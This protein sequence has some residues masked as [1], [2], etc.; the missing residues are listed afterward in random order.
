MV[1]TCGREGSSFSRVHRQHARLVN[2]RR[3]QNV[4]SQN[5]MH[6]GELFQRTPRQAAA[7][8]I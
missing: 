3:K 6:D 8:S 7:V 1:T 4:G 5:G 2:G